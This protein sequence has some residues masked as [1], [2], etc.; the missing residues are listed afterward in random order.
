MP[1]GCAAQSR[2]CLVRSGELLPFRDRFSLTF[3]GAAWPTA[4]ASHRQ[5]R[6]G[7]EPDEAQAKDED[8]VGGLGGDGAGGGTD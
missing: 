4:T 1:G 6:L 8:L 2:G 7:E 5:T 3:D